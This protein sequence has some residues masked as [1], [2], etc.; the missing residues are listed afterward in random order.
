MADRSKWDIGV[1]VADD[2]PTMRYYLTSLIN[3]TPGMH[4]VG[5]ARDGEEVL[6]LVP[7]LKPNVISMDINMPHMNGL[8]ATRRVMVDHPT[9]VVVVSSLVEHDVELSFQAIQSGALAVVEKPPDRHHPMFPQKHQQL[10]KTLMAMAG[11]RVIRRGKTGPLNGSQP[12]EAAL[13]LPQRR[14]TVMPE[15]VA[16]GASAGGPS[17]LSKLLPSLPKDF[18]APIVIAQHIPQE[19]VNGLARWL[20]KVSALPVVVATDGITLKAGVVHLSPGTAHITVVRRGA[21][22]AIQLIREQGGHRYQPSVDV[23][24]R[25]V[26]V[27]CGAAAVGLVLTGM[28]DDGAAGLLAMRE[29]GARTFAQD[30]RTATVF[31][32]PSAAITVGAVEAVLPLGSLPSA[33][34]KAVQV[35]KGLNTP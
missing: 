23:L 22:L 14:S 1:L 29:A 16:I 20:N 10:I 4:V 5:E 8:E 24:F 17:A 3:E 18:P 30:E 2:S 15:V 28:G 11:V 35:T 7:Q 19:F 9:P 21:T 32:M 12:V 13:E 33:L 31:G 34:K 25:S 27:V 6:K 26:A